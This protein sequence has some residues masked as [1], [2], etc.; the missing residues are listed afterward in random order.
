[1]IMIFI[2]MVMIME[3]D[4]AVQEVSP[5]RHCCILIIIVVII[6]MEM[7]MM[8]IIIVILK[9]SNDCHSNSTW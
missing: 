7:V 8:I 4:Q 6:V 3:G 1:M 5:D 9:Q 2:V